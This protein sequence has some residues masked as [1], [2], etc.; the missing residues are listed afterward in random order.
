MDILKKIEVIEGRRRKY[1]IR[2]G[3]MSLLMGILGI[4]LVFIIGGIQS[5]I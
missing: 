2:Y 1:W 5:L 4:G 3:L